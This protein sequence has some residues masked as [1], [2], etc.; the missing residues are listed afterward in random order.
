MAAYEAS[1]L[2][3][4]VFCKQNGLAPSSF[5]KWRRQL[6]DKNLGQEAP[7]EKSVFIELPRQA[8]LPTAPLWDIEVEL[9]NGIALKL[10][11]T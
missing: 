2:I 6:R 10:R 11:R 8:I 7:L 1:G 9:G 3:Q 4:K 5:A